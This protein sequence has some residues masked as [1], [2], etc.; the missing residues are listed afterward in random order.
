MSAGLAE[1]LARYDADVRRI[2][3]AARRLVHSD[4]PLAKTAARR[5]LGGGKRLRA[6]VALLSGR[7]CGLADKV[8]DKIAIGIEII[9][10][11]T[12]MHDDVVDEAPLRRSQATANQLYGN[13]A[14]VLVGDFLYS[15]ASQILAEVGSLPLLAWIAD[16][17]NRLAEGEVLQLQRSGKR[18]GG[19]VYF[20]IIGRKT[21][22]LFET[23]AAAAALVSGDRK[24]LPALAAYGRHLGIAFQLI[25]DCLDY[26]GAGD[27]T[28]KKIGADFGEG[29]MT[30]PLILALEKAEPAA[31]RR[32]L[33]GWRRGDESSFAAALQLVRDTGALAE[34]RRR[35]AAAAEKAAAALAPCP[36]TPV[37]QTLITLAKAS[38][39]RK[40]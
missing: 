8:S 6:V 21:A 7:L 35:A 4:V 2:G 24:K 39:K 18:I 25:D 23:A 17:T 38:V 13:A 16:S 19:E 27:E 40:K 3:A 11:A 30:L 15:R 12:L 22:N 9:H 37:R 29:K 1:E 33:A 32:L 14:A 20:D 31:R 28:G 5:H 34:T 36:D 26:A 10:T